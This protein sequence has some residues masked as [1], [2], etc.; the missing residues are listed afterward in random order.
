[1]KRKHMS[2]MVS[3]A[4]LLKGR[5]LDFL[6]P[7][8]TLHSAN[9]NLLGANYGNLPHIVK[10]FVRVLNTALVT[11]ELSTRMCKVLHWVTQSSSAVGAVH[12]VML[13]VNYLNNIMSASFYMPFTFPNPVER[14]WTSTGVSGSGI[15]SHITQDEGNIAVI[16]VRILDIAKTCTNK[17]AAVGADVTGGIVEGVDLV[18]L[19]LN[20]NST[21]AQAPHRGFDFYSGPSV[22]PPSEV[23]YQVV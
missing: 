15:R 11:P 2:A 9:V 19:Y 1:M 21:S 23:P 8:D 14:E 17:T 18:N 4:I 5:S 10:I 16:F 13:S 6:F 12:A 3:Y 7:S 22:E 20:F